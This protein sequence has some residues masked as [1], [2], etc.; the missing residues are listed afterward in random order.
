MNKVISKEYVEKNYIHKDKI[1]EI[2]DF[3]VNAT[4]NRDSYLTGMCNG[5]IY[6]KSIITGKDPE[7]ME[8]TKDEHK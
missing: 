8:V 5:M 3:A 6:I 7:Y 1:I 4:G 2:I